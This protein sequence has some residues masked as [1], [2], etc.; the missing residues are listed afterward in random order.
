MN[1]GNR[2][3]ELR[4]QRGITQ[5]QLADCVGV[6]FQAVSKWENGIALPDITLA[7]VLASY[8]GVSMDDLFD[9][10][11]KEIEEKA[12]AIAKESWK[13]RDHDWEKAR[14]IIDEGLKEYPDND[15]LLL[16]R[17]YV[18]D[19]D[20][21]PDEAIE[22]ATRII[23][24]TKDAANK[25][26]AC[27]CMAYAYK[28][29]ND[30][31]SAR[32]AIDLIPEF[33]FSNLQLKASILE[34]EEK[35]DATCKEFGE[36][37]HGLMFIMD[38]MADCYEAKGEYGDAVKTYEDAIKVLDILEVKEGWYRLREKFRERISELQA[39]Q[40]SEQT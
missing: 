34:G 4:K 11:V 30:L 39:K 9:F 16:N 12:F 33:Y 6:S 20:S 17:L 23:D 19:V 35:W 13:Y 29:K 14:N 28:S 2:I 21:N 22:V 24:K 1:I 37:L 31:E 36:S 26:D 40:I 10:N 18:M 32:K 25:Y 27:R 7:P 3:R 38:I 15:I 5:E 8:F